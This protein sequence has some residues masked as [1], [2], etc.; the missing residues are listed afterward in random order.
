MIWVFLS[1][2]LSTNSKTLLWTR[3]KI[4]FSGWSQR[5]CDF[6]KNHSRWLRKSQSLILSWK[7]PFRGM[8]ITVTYRRF[9]TNLEHA[10]WRTF[11]VRVR[12]WRKERSI[13]ACAQSVHFSML[14]LYQYDSRPQPT[15]EDAVPST[16]GSRVLTLR[17]NAFAGHTSS[18]VPIRA[19]VHSWSNSYWAPSK[20]AKTW[21]NT[22]M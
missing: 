9:V 20:S 7:F 10:K 14:R 11:L 15:G 22:Y 5:H 8:E 2:G 12:V 6:D 18:L 3:W 16:H 19:R 1:K 13:S 17:T 4:S 21:R